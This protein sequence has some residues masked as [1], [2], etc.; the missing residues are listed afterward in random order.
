MINGRY[1]L[2]NVTSFHIRSWHNDG[3]SVKAES[4]AGARGEIQADFELPPCPRGLLSCPLV[5]N[6]SIYEN[7]NG[8][9]FL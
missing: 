5:K 3:K 7:K 1:V 8:R 9:N 2:K 6:P 4:L